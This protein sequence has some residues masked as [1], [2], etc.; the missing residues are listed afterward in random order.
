MVSRLARLR[1]T[2]GVGYIKYKLMLKVFGET[3]VFDITEEPIVT[4]AASSEWNLPDDL[5]TLRKIVHRQKIDL[6]SSS[7][8]KMLKAALSEKNLKQ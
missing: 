2:S 4:P 5:I 6:D 7:T 1:Q 8:M 3:G